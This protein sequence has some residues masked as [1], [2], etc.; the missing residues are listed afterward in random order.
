MNGPLAPDELAGLIAGLE[1]SFVEFKD[2]RVDPASVAKELCGFANADGGRLLI[3]VDDDGVLVGAAGW[4]DD[5]RVMNVARTAIDPP[6]TPTFQRIVLSGQAVVVVGVGVGAGVEKPYAVRSGETRRYYVRVGSTTREASREELIR[7]TQASGAVAPDLRPVPGA[8]VADLDPKAIAGRFA[9]RRTLDFDALSAAEREEVLAAAEILDAQSRTPTIGGLLCFGRRPQD[10]LP[11][12]TVACTAYPGESVV[13]EMVDHHDATGRV[14]EQIEAAVAFVMRNLR[15]GSSVEGT[16]RVSTARLSRESFR[17]VVANA[18]GHRHY[19]ITGPVQ[20]R[21]FS[22]RVEIV[23]PG[24][25]P[26]GVTPASMRAG[27]SVR[28]NQFVFA[29][30]VELG[31]VDAV[32]RGLVLLF[33]E[34]ADLGLPEPEISV[35]EGAWTRLVLKHPSAPGSAGT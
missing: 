4:E 19:G 26:N 17:E 8:T 6:I 13:R 22:D 11:Y 2:P 7:L 27:V 30:L 16:R 21:V 34:A 23:S 10:R 14:D 24:A 1:N 31:L 9:G 28:R 15:N 20:L 18:V 32:G 5:T 25:P 3:G 35:E 33:E 12:A 29:R